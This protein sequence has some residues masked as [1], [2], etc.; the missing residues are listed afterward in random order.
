MFKI[1]QYEKT[2]I[3]LTLL[4]IVVIG[5][6]L[7][8]WVIAFALPLLALTGMLYYQLY[9][10]E[11]WLDRGGK[12]VEVDDHGGLAG[13]IIRHLYR[14]KKIH[15]KRK[16]KTKELLRRLNTNIAALPDAT[17]LLNGQ[18]EIVWFNDAATTLLRL[19]RQDQGQVISNLIRQPEFLDYLHHP[20][21]QPHI[22]IPC[23]F[24]HRQTL[25]YKIVSFGDNQRLVIIRNISEQVKLQQALK[26][27]IANASH[28][29][30]TPL[31][32]IVGYAEILQMEPGLSE[33][34]K[35]SVSVIDQQSRRMQDLIRDLLHLSRIESSS[36]QPDE[37]E[38]IDIRATMQSVLS[39]L[40]VQ[41]GSERLQCHHETTDKLR[42]NSTDIHC[43]CKNLLENALKYSDAEHPVRVGWS[44]TDQG[45]LQ[46]YVED[47]GE[48]L[49]EKEIPLLTNR[50]YR[51]RTTT[52]RQITGSGLGLAIVE[53]AALRH[54]GKLSIDSRKNQ[55]SRFCVTFPAYRTIPATPSTLEPPMP[56]IPDQG[57]V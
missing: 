22:E 33:I 55:G 34:G 37:G 13:L 1:W 2:P 53:Q 8:N 24:D 40:A 43:I 14:Q 23:A 16:K 48:G 20:D 10:L 21:A 15:N 30:K 6:T 54:G 36:L 27:F 12:L 5:L 25:Q 32:S 51:G 29:M 18:Y 41:C 9:T 19:Q 39:A 46:F 52:A 47:Q 35:K 3:L 45:E 44:Q 31:T 7:G 57:H 50:Y 4:A 26:D 56:S 38:E 28:E 49:D 11:K 42:G 17:V